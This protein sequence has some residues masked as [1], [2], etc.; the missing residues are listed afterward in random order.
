MTGFLFAVSVI[1]VAISSISFPSVVFPFNRIGTVLLF[2]KGNG[3][4]FDLHL[5]G[6]LSAASFPSID[7]KF[8][9]ASF[10][11]LFPLV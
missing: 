6:L 1:G 4:F 5:H 9:I 7:F 11:V 3:T 10:V 8:I 2:F